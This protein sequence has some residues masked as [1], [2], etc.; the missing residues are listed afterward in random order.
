[1]FSAL[2]AIGATSPSGHKTLEELHQVLFDHIY[3]VEARVDQLAKRLEATMDLSQDQHNSML[4]I[5]GRVDEATKSIL[6]NEHHIEATE[7]KV[8]QLREEVRLAVPNLWGPSKDPDD[9]LEGGISTEKLRDELSESIKSAVSLVKGDFVAQATTVAD[10]INQ[11]EADMK[12]QSAGMEQLLERMGSLE[13]AAEQRLPP[14][15][16]SEEVP[17][18]GTPSSSRMNMM[19]G[20]G[21]LHSATSSRSSAAMNS[22]PAAL[23]M[24]TD[25]LQLGLEQ[26]AL[27]DFGVSESMVRTKSSVRSRSQLMRKMLKMVSTL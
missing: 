12:K 1:M 5:E 14:R 20:R 23:N 25:L 11:I 10:L 9:G 21:Q 4:K 13:Q 2:E 17:I 15:R 8:A 16:A 19:M 22:N 7:R 6:E 27:V 26:D 3:S 24:G 18:A